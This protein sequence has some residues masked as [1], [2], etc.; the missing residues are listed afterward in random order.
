MIVYVKNCRKLDLIKALRTFAFYFYAILMII[1]CKTGEKTISDISRHQPLD[2]VTTKML[3]ISEKYIDGTKEK[4]LSNY[5]S[6]EELF[7]ECLKIDP[8]YHPAFY[9]LAEISVNKEKYNDA[10]LWI[11]KAVERDKYNIWYQVK[12]ADILVALGRYGK[13]DEVYSNIIRENPGN[14]SFY[15]QQLRYRIIAGDLT[16][17][18]EA[19]Q[20]ILDE[21]GFDETIFFIMIDLYDDLGRKRRI[22][23]SLRWL[24]QKFPYE[25]RYLGYFASFY[26]S[27]GNFSKA[28]PLWNEILRLEPNNGEVYFELANYYRSKGDEEKAFEQL[29][30]AFKTPNLN[31]DAKIAV[32]ISYYDI[33]ENH[34]ELMDEAYS[35]LDI[36]IEKHPENPKGWAMYADFLY[37]DERYREAHDKFI[38]VVNLDSSRY[39]VWEQLL[40]CA[41]LLKDFASLKKNGERALRMY[42]EQ[43]LIYLYYAHGLIYSGQTEKARQVLS[44]GR[45]FIAFNDSLSAAFIHALA[46]TNEIDGNFETARDNYNHAINLNPTD[47]LLIADYMRFSVIN[48]KKIKTD[49]EKKQLLL[50]QL[51]KDSPMKDIA[52]LWLISGETE[53]SK[54]VEKV[55]KIIDSNN[56]N[57]NV[58]EHAGYMFIVSGNYDKAETVLRKA[59]AKSNGNSLIMDHIND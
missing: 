23:R 15:E 36:I 41:F 32:M 27:Q 2:S 26:S 14:K 11:E 43:A 10:L 44:Q 17:A 58:L 30:R 59:L 45:F 5:G 24:T 57:Y 34:P 16:S 31:I 35:L 29:N 54:F 56:D 8:E 39:L 13:A 18:A 50:S 19:C 47:I 48:S 3:V 49:P 20:K 42:P 12:Y 53:K 37:R 46:R 7:K 22:E 25:T 1:S 52:N 33:T 6:A 21:F 55:E 51:K 4:I 40:N 28:L 9:Q 38:T